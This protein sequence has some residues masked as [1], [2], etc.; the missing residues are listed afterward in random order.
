MRQPQQRNEKPLRQQHSAH[1]PAKTL[2]H[3][4][5]VHNNDNANNGIDFL[6]AKISEPPK[7]MR[8]PA[9][10][11]WH[12]SIPL[13]QSSAWTYMDGPSTWEVLKSIRTLTHG[14]RKAAMLATV[15]PYVSLVN[16]FAWTRSDTHPMVPTETSTKRTL[17]E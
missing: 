11:S 9:P 4:L 13:R 17:N 15:R 12:S 5:F 3:R 6:P 14:V 2:A 8:H 1:E 16:P 7:S 10:L